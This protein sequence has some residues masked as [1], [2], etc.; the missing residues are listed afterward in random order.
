MDLCLH[1]DY[2]GVAMLWYYWF[3][4][5]GFIY[6]CHSKYRPARNFPSQIKPIVQLQQ[7]VT[8]HEKV[9]YGKE[10]R[11]H[12]L[13]CQ[14]SR[15]LVHC[16]ILQ[17]QK[18]GISCTIFWNMNIYL[19]EFDGSKFHMKLR[20]CFDSIAKHAHKPLEEFQI[21]IQEFDVVFCG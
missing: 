7:Y 9:W 13:S 19:N 14:I 17:N 3:C 10:N 11:R 1:G 8:V 4:I 5:L 20:F 21:C 6:P 16:V 18:S 15:W 2:S 12:A